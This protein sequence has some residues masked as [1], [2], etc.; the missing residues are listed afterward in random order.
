MMEA[1]VEAL[2]GPKGR[3]DP[4]RRAVRHGRDDGL[5][6]LGGRQVA[7][8]RPRVRSADGTADPAGH[9]RL[10]HL[11]RGARAVR[12]L[13]PPTGGLGPGHR[14]PDPPRSLATLGAYVRIHEA[15]EDSAATQLGV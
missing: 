8:R 14:P 3:H 12:H 15:W 7:I 13:R 5:V 11:D 10:R 6:T 9:L 4:G 2:V 1:E